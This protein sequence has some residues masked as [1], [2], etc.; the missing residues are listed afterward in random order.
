MKTG[1]QII[2]RCSH[3]FKNKIFQ[4]PLFLKFGEALQILQPLDEAKLGYILTEKLFDKRALQF[5]SVSYNFV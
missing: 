2:L 5:G 3:C 1:I 4:T